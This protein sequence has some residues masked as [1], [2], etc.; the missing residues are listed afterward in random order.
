MIITGSIHSLVTR[1]DSMFTCQSYSQNKPLNLF[2]SPTLCKDCATKQSQ[3]RARIERPWPDN[4]MHM[5]E[6]EVHHLRKQQV[7]NTSQGTYDHD[8][9][10]TFND[11]IVNESH[12]TMQQLR[13]Q[14]ITSHRHHHRS[15]CALLISTII[16]IAVLGT[17]VGILFWRIKV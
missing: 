3:R 15:M 9:Q 10:D 11:D 17:F 6:R 16:A 14:A 8:R 12:N 2:L 7:F 5:L 13:L 1:L 4:R